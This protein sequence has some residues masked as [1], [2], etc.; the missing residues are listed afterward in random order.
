MLHLPEGHMPQ[1]IVIGE[2]HTSC[3]IGRS[4][5]LDSRKTKGRAE[6]PITKFEKVGGHCNIFRE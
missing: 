2:R 4:K 5:Q 1:L 6:G 3:S